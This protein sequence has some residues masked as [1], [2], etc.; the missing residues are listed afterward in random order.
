V[1]RPRLLQTVTVA[2]TGAFLVAGCGPQQAGEDRQAAGG[3]APGAGSTAASAA[4]PAPRADELVPSSGVLAG[5]NLDWGRQTLRHY[6]DGLGHRPA[7]AVNFARFPF[8]AQDEANVRAAQAQVRAEGGILLLTLEPHEGLDRVTP[9]AADDLAVLLDGFNREG[10]PV[11]VRFA[12]EMNGSWYPWG[13]QPEAF[14]AAFGRVADSLHRLAPGSATMWAPNYGGGYPFAGGQF[15]ARAGTRDAATLDTDGDGRASTADDPYAPYYPGDDAV[16]WVGM[17]LYHWGNEYPW[18]ENE[19][20]EEGKFLQQ[21]TG[22]YDGAGGDDTAVPDFYA[23][24][25]RDRDK[26]VAIPETAA[27]YAPG[28]G[29]AEELDVK[30]A[31]WRQLTD[32][33]IPREYP[34]V[35][36]VNWFEWRKHEPETGGAVDWR[37][38]GEPGIAGAYVADLPPWY[39][40]AEQPD[41]C[42]AP[43]R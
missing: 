36:M 24:Y 1:R 43:Q 5:V 32:P 2:V 29:G 20:P 40:Y 7:V 13:Q 4:C 3:E 16:D 19:V 14:R 28:G 33:V 22:T 38:A 23:E 25:G 12:H 31:W 27:L 18:G 17:T 35:K 26:P 6:A 11:I 21:L 39:H 15:A 9:R 30:R 41:D 34:Q 10:V 8:A 37:A 42:A